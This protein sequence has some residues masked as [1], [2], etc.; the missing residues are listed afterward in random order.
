M[1]TTKDEEPSDTEVARAMIKYF[2]GEKRDIERWVG[3]DGE[4]MG[5]HMPHILHLWVEYREAK[6]RLDAAIK[7]L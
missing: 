4:W 6:K 3:Y 7:D 1:S 2:W 5:E